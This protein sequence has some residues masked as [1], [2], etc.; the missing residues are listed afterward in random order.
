MK[1][2]CYYLSIQLIRFL[3][4]LP[5]KRTYW[6]IGDQLLRSGTSIG[7][8]VIEAKS[9]SSK[10]DFIKYYEI[11]LKSANESKYWLGLLR[12]ATDIKSPQIKKL[13]DEVNQISNMLG[14]SVITLKNKKS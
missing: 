12:D 1:V 3:N 7:A 6:V 14:S 13:L 2:R 10:K 4:T 11:A 9:A 5:E 8:N